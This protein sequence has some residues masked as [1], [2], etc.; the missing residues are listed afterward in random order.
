MAALDAVAQLA[1]GDEAGVAA[2]ALGLLTKDGGRGEAT[3]RQ[4]RLGAVEA[5]RRLALDGDRA[6]APRLAARLQ[7]ADAQVT[8]GRIIKSVWNAHI[9]NDLDMII[10]LF[11]TMQRLNSFGYV[12]F[13]SS[14]L[15]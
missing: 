9:S 15:N 12:N 6:A 7:D 10:M 4:V 3:G 13:Y 11:E 2:G 8:Q 14:I 1:L 5:L